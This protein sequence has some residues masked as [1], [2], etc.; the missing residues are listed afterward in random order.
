M[1]DVC[2]A[3][4]RAPDVR[5]GA[6]LHPEI[7]PGE[8]DGRRG[9]L[10]QGPPRQAEREALRPARR[11]VLGRRASPAAACSWTWAATASPSATGSS[12]GRRIKDVYCQIGTYVHADKTRG[13]DDCLCILEF[14][15]GAVGLVEDSW[16]RL[17][18]MDDR[19][20]GLRL[21]RAHLR[22][23]AHGQRPAHLFS[24]SGYGYAVEKAAEHAGAGATR[25]SRSS[26]TT[27][28]RRRCTTSPAASAARRRRSP[29]ARTAA[30]PAGDVCGVSIGRGR[31]TCRHRQFDPSGVAKPIDL[32]FSPLTS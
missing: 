20:R 15:G 19:D 11:L 9:R 22:Q 3:E 6:L 12:A 28:S 31:A 30:C 13:E 25:S 23:P 2:R 7:R 29:P 24:E 14:E 1:I 26:G 5:R 18:G 10:R 16:A 17:G 4:G 32:W 21:R 8:G 27:A